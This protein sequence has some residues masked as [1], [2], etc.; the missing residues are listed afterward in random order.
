MRA[1][2]CGRL[3]DADTVQQG[4]EFSFAQLDV[5][6]VRVVIG[7]PKRPLVQTLVQL[8]HARPVVEQDLQCRPALWLDQR[9]NARDVYPLPSQN[10][11]ELNPLA[12]HSCTRPDHSAALAMPNN[13]MW[14]GRLRYTAP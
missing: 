3:L 12:C 14:S 11:R 5:R 4:V 6:R 1:S 7:G 9:N 13:L 10:A 8:A 2:L